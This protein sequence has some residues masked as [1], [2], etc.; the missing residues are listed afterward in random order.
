MPLLDAS[1]L[2]NVTSFNVLTL[3][4]SC[5]TIFVTVYIS[6]RIIK[7]DMKK[8]SDD[9]FKAKA[10]VYFVEKLD[11][12]AHKRMTKIQTDGESVSKQMLKVSE[13]VAWIRG[14]LDPNKK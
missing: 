4:A 6:N 12:A 10:D 8:E 11:R 3:G 14:F 9:K 5:V 13:D 1:S 7:R 2:I